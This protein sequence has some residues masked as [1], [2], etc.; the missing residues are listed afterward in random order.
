M[1]DSIADITLGAST[2]GV[3]TPLSGSL[4]ID[5]TTG[6]LVSSALFL[7]VAGV[8][9]PLLN[10]ALSTNPTTG[11]TTVTANT[12]ASGLGTGV[13]LS[14]TGTN[15]A[16]VTTSISALGVPVVSNT[17][18]VTTVIVCFCTGT[19][20]RTARDGRELDVAV[21]ALA[22]GDLVVTASG[23]HRPIRWIGHRNVACRSHPRAQVAMP[24]RVAAHAFGDNRPA[25]DL[26]VS[27]GHSLCVDVV[28]EV[29]IPASALINGTTITQDDVEHVTY[30]H[31]ELDSHD[32][33]LA[34][35]MP[36]E[37]YLEMGNRLF[38][39]E[40]DVVALDASPDVPVVTHADFCR[41]FHADGAL[42][43]VVRAQ[44]AARA[45][46][47][48]WTLDDQGL[49]DLHLM[50]D[51]VRLDPQV[52]GLAVRFTVPAAARD[53]WLVSSTSSPA[54]ISASPDTRTLG[55]CLH[56]LA[57]DDGF[58]VPLEIKGDDP[59]LCVGFHGVE[60]EGEIKRRWTAGCALLPASLW[61]GV[62]GEFFLRIELAF[63][64]LPRWAAPVPVAS[65]EVL[66]RLV[67]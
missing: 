12:L 64:A 25:R 10:V 62:Q 41:P 33:L 26:L 47:L 2:I 57:I 15:P 14:F 9:E 5:T 35:N 13:T 29:L 67:A 23:E 52:R 53:V 20:I 22:V 39:A 7:N 18:S 43:E 3:S 38:F 45:P 58:G 48:G 21:E 24:V 55:V 42:V 19:L 66:P 31:V 51:G 63:A 40:G 59:R 54:T 11:V 46:R 50:V 60:H 30:W 65:A 34:E 27:P 49:G 16:T 1:P 6:L 44:L 56:T 8:Q 28:G 37:S 36:T 17:V 61:D 4:N 32:I